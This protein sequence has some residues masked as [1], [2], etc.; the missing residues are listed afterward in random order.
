M[1]PPRFSE[2]ATLEIT[3]TVTSPTTGERAKGSATVRS[4]SQAAACFCEATSRLPGLPLHSTGGGGGSSA[5]TGGDIYVYAG[6][7]SSLADPPSPAAEASWWDKID[8]SS[9]AFVGGMAAAGV[10]V[11]GLVAGAAAIVLI[12]KRREKEKLAAREASLL[13]AV[14]RGKAFEAAAAAEAAA[15]RKSTTTSGGAAGAGG[16]GGGGNSKKTRLGQTPTAATAPMLLSPGGGMGPPAQ[17]RR[18]V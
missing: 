10:A 16:G 6:S 5:G 1:D 12:R 15:A 13:A 11:A 2:I 9:P 4:C 7:L 3:A 18:A 8:K 14:A 17:A